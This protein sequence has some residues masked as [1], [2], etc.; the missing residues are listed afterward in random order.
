MEPVENPLN[1]ALTDAAREVLELRKQV[2]TLTQQLIDAREASERICEGYE[3][4]L[5]DDS[6][7]KI[8]LIEERNYWLI[9]CRDLRAMLEVVAPEALSVV[10]DGSDIPF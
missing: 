5:F 7:E 4:L 6:Q 9:R 10:D 8:R 3:K 1:Y 2:A